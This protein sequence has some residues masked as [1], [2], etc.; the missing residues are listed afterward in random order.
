MGEKKRPERGGKVIKKKKSDLGTLLY[1]GGGETDDTS[2]AEQ[3]ASKAP[4]ADCEK[5]AKSRGDTDM[6][7]FRGIRNANAK[8]S[9]R[10][11]AH[12]QLCDAKKD[13]RSQKNQRRKDDKVRKKERCRLNLMTVLETAIQ[14][15]MYGVSITGTEGGKPGE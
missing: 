2:G 7:S 1:W 3:T 14:G 10:R 8:E 12:A 11:A 5:E 9:P 15:G 4:A 6:C 13:Q